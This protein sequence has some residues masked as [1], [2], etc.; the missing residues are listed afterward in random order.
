VGLV[1]LVV[2]RNKA[3]AREARERYEAEVSEVHGAL[4]ALDLND[5]HGAE[6]AIELAEEKKALWSAHALAPE[7]ESLAA[8]ART[9]LSS[10]KERR[11]ALGRF[12]AIE[13]QLAQS[14]LTA[15][16]LKELRRQL[17]EGEARLSDGGVEL[18]AR[19]GLARQK[20]E[21]GY[22]ARLLEEA[23]VFA[24]EQG[25][26]PSL[27]RF[28][29]VED[30]LK[31]L[32]DRAYGQKNKELQDFFTPLYQQAIAESDRLAAA[33]FQAEGD[34][35]AWTDC[36]VAPQSANWNASAVRG[37]SH[38]VDGSGLQV[39]G[40][41]PDA[42][43]LAVVSIGDREQWRH[44]QLD[45]EFVPEK[46]DVD[47]YFRLGRGPNQNTLSLPLRTTGGDSKLVPGKTYQARISVIGSNL[48]VRWLGDDIDTPGPYD[49]TVTWV[50]NRKGAIGLIVS[51]EARFT[52]TRFRVRELR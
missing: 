11:E 26:R 5:P 37:F 24:A 32:L 30:E 16:E 33:L 36:L 38:R 1:V 19:F 49:E 50:M 34:S 21:R 46:G 25:P 9:N 40:P 10:A 18:V 20:A 31:T 28:Q 15:D 45:V 12:T 29:G 35:L 42:G 52:F 43:K 14:G 51:P 39:V 22:A 23:R 13:E 41:D 47:L 44:F 27:V 7:I 17:D 48:S 8:K 4:L 6:R 3:A 2:Y